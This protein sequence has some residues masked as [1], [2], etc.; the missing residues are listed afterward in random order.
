MVLDVSRTLGTESVVVRTVMESSLLELITAN[1]AVM[2]FLRIC[3]LQPL[4][5]SARSIVMLMVFFFLSLLFFSSYSLQTGYQQDALV[6]AE[7][8]AVAV[9]KIC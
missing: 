6:P 5:G 2:H 9:L 4:G 3:H 7:P 1:D 8:R